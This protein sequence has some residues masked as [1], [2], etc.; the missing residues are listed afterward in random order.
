VNVEF[1]SSFARDLRSI[2]DRNLLKRIQEKIDEVECAQSLSEISK[3]KKL[4]GHTDYY[5]IR[6]GD[7]RLGITAAEDTVVFVR[8]LNRKDIYRHFP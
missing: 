6:I 2:R 5:R 1:R 7:Y 4:G 8:F 3:L